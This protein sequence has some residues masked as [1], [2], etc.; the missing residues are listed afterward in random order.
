MD[1]ASLVSQLGAFAVA[2]GALAWL[3]K[4]LTT[5]RLTIDVEKLKLNM[6]ADY[7]TQLERLRT[8]LRVQAER[9]L[10]SLKAELRV[11][12][13][14]R[15]VRYA[16][17]QERRMMVVSDLYANLTSMESEFASLMSPI[18][19]AG[20]PSETEKQATAVE[21]GNRFMGHFRQN[22]I[23][24]SEG[25]CKAIDTVWD[26]H[27]SAWIDFT[28]GRPGR[29]AQDPDVFRAAF[30]SRRKAWETISREVPA[31]RK[32]IEQ[33]MRELLGV[34]DGA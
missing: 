16:K 1:F 28:L 21:A 23:F 29:T 25:V 31:I 5:H 33:N 32:A 9:E 18:Q 24:F 26:H 19:W 10:E 13:Y 3:A 17:L 11:S 12:A 15:E 20:T 7:D 6:R 30:E 34:L 22:R 2:S 14:T 4:S 8:E 27:Q